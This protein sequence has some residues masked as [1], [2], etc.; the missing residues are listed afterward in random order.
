MFWVVGAG[1]IHAQAVWL[2]RVQVINRVVMG[3]FQGKDCGWGSSGIG[4][5]CLPGALRCCVGRVSGYKALLIGAL[6]VFSALGL[7]VFQV[8]R[9]SFLFSVSSR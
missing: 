7:H 1:L 6:N 2:G 9:A 5:G 8:V 3:V 4:A